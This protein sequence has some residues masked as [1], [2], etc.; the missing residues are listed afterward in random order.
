MEA[1]VKTTSPITIDPEDYYFLVF[2]IY[3]PFSCISRREVHGYLDKKNAFAQLKRFE[4]AHII[5]Y[6][7]YRGEI[8]S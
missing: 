8:I 6:I 3:H 1:M 7:Q 2:P 5:C 4:K